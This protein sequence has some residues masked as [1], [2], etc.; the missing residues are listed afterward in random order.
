MAR[1]KS[2]N[3]IANDKY[4]YDYDEL[5]PGEKAAVT[6]IYNAQSGSTS[7]S[8]AGPNFVVAKAGRIGNGVIEKCMAPGTTVEELF[9]EAKLD[10]SDKEGI[11]AVSTGQTVDLDEE[12]VNGETYI[13]APEIKS[14]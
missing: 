11:T 7:V 4:D 9:E 13:L 5:E 8:R 10:L 6:R 2:K 1:K 3:V 12:I 14:A